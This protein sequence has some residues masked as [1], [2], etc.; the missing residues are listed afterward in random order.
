MRPLVN[1]LTIIRNNMKL[2]HNNKISLTI[3][4]V[5]YLSLMYG[6]INL[7]EYKKIHEFLYN[8]KP[9]TLYRFLNK[10]SNLYWSHNRKKPRLNYLNKHIKNLK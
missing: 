10:K 4:S 7:I 8:N 2:I 5:V 6:H 3:S 1:L 9:N